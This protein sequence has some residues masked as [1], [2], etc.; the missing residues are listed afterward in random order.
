MRQYKRSLFPFIDDFNIQ[1]CASSFDLQPGV[2]VTRGVSDYPSLATD[3]RNEPVEPVRPP[4]EP[5]P[6]LTIVH[7]ATVLS[8]CVVPV[9][10]P[11]YLAV[12][13]LYTT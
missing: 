6:A 7:Y 12:Q 9:P 3:C 10:P 8:Q 5:V 11:P 4:P 2:E 1:T 13:Y